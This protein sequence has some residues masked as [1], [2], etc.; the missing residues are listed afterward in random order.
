MGGNIKG[1]RK[2]ID[3]REDTINGWV[4]SLKGF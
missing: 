1:T 3:G 4:N 2:T